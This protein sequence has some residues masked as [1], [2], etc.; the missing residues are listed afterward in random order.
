MNLTMNPAQNQQG[1]KPLP[2]IGSA[3][4]CVYCYQTL[5]NETAKTTRKRLLARH[6]CAERELVKRPAAPPPYN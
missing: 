2:A 5:G 3:V 6:H 1:R 4:H